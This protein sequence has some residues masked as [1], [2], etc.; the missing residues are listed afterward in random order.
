MRLFEKHIF[1]C[2]NQRAEGA[3]RQCCGEETGLELTAAFKSLITEHKLKMK[4]RAQRASCFDWCEN[5]PIITIYP[6]GVVYGN[7]QKSDVEEIFNEHILNN[8][9]VTRLKTQFSK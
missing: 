6:E 7:V 8:R 9:P 4:V 2:I 1:I 3:P 5:G